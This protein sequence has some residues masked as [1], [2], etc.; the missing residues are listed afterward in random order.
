MG[1][2]RKIWRSTFI[3]GTIDTIGNIID[4]GSVVDGFKRTLKEDV[5]EDDPIGKAIY[6]IGK[7]DGK[8]SG[9][10][11]AS[12]EYEKKLLE[13]ADLF[14]KQKKIYEK[15]REQYEA[16]LNEYED[17]I[18]RLEAKINKTEVEKEYLRELLIKDRQLRKLMSA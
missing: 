1:L 11:K 4:E 14:L 10:V 6:N 8:K 2:L 9:Y 3:G 15:E 17:E 18:E 16:L 13:Q 5:C 12:E 7:Y